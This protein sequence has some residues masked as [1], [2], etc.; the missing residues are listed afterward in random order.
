MSLAVQRACTLTV[1]LLLL[2]L[3][4]TRGGAADWTNLSEIEPKRAAW[5][6]TAVQLD[7]YR[8]RSETLIAQLGNWPV[9]MNTFRGLWDGRDAVQA[10]FDTATQGDALAS[11]DAQTFIQA[12][13][14][15][16]EALGA[17]VLVNDPT[18]SISQEYLRVE[19]L[20]GTTKAEQTSNLEIVWKTQ[21]RDATRVLGKMLADNGIAE[22]EVRRYRLA[23]THSQ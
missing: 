13:N 2:V 23:S 8:T 16:N 6:S 11:G 22:D 9:A 17:L 3:A 15:A 20:V 5:L 7:A 12:Y 21:M 1:L 19:I 18:A 10:T 14:A 4:C